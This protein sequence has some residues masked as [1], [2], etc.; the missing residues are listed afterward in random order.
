MKLL[1]LS[2]HR[3]D[4]YAILILNTPSLEINHMEQTPGLWAPPPTDTNRLHAEPSTSA[5][6]QPPPCS[7]LAWSQ[8]P[9]LLWNGRP[10]P[11]LPTLLG[12]R[13]WHMAPGAQPAG[14]EGKAG[15]RTPGTIP[16]QTQ[17]TAHPPVLLPQGN[18][19]RL[20]SH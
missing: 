10:S 9:G 13:L 2:I 11:P 4:F 18:G 15:G 1:I 8:E 17:L 6:T 3:H 19:P 14:A 7:S 20:A 12:S 5:S 16:R